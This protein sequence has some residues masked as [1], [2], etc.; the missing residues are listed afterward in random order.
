ME[1][2]KNKCIECINKYGVGII[3]NNLL[4]E[5]SIVEKGL[6]SGIYK[7]IFEDKKRIFIVFDEELYFKKELG[8]GVCLN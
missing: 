4:K 3:M 8:M 7:I 2:D 6:D 1:L 5:L